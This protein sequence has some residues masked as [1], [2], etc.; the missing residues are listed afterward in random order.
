VRIALATCERSVERDTDFDYIAPALRRRGAEVEAPAWTD[1]EVDWS[2][3]DLVLVS[4]TWDYHTQADRFRS[5][6]RVVDAQTRL[7][8]ELETIEWNI[9]K[10]YLRELEAAAVPVIPTL[11]IEAGADGEALRAIAAEG[12]EDIIVKPVVDLGAKRLARVRPETVE[13]VL[14]RIDEPAMAQPFLGSVEAEGE[15]SI[16]MIEGEAHHA[17]RKLPA[18]GDFRVQPMYGGTHERI[19]PPPAAL[20]IARAAVAAAPGDPLYARVDLVA[21]ADGGLLLIELELIEPAFYLDVAPAGAELMARAILAA[22][23]GR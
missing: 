14:G 20:E 16:L 2:T 17:L 3:F 13:T 19:E 9:D 23:A 7:R 1:P 5:W 10:R 8:N 18:P 12:W 21:E 4:S 6:L 15:L 22:A 11:W